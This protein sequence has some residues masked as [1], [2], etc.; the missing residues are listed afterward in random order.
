MRNEQGE[1]YRIAG[2]A[3][4]I[5]E[6]KVAEQNLQL[7]NKGLEQ[8]VAERTEELREEKARLL[9]LTEQVPAIMWT[10]DREL[11]FLSSAGSGLA[12]IGLKPDEI[13]G[14]TLQ[15]YL[16]TDD[17]DAS[18]LV[19][20]QSA[21]AGKSAAYMVEHEGRI[22][23]CHIQP[24]R[25]S[26]G[27]VVGVAGIAID[28]TERKLLEAKLARAGKMSVLARLAAGIAHEI[29]NPLA[30]MEALVQR[31]DDPY[32]SD[33]V[34][35]TADSLQNQVDRIVRIVRGVS[36]L[37]MQSSEEWSTCNIRQMLE[38]TLQ[39]LKADPLSR[40]K[41][42]SVNGGRL[43]MIQG[44]YDQLLQVFMNLSQNALDAMI[45][46]DTL[47]IAAVLADS[48]IRIEFQDSGSGMSEAVKEQ[49]FDPFYT[50]KGETHMGMGLSLCHDIIKSHGGRI[51]VESKEGEGS[52]F[53]VILPWQATSRLLSAEIEKRLKH[54]EGEGSDRGMD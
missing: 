29:G 54:G 47:T 38:E 22:L 42:L 16:Q 15:E 40:A 1:V 9:H 17:P 41:H 49:L 13:A 10:V 37:A 19:H 34:R 18:S 26:S 36:S 43:P 6:R 30:S 4:D 48:Q 45:P 25:E 50:T 33:I 31:L 27:A 52:I 28:V 46:G 51:E 7:L 2:V 11:R 21:L 12:K 23:D 24:L 44:S 20:H 39:V 35:K 53:T 3:D 32:D 14:L 8:R 5:T